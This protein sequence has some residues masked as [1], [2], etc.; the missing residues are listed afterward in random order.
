MTT[1]TRVNWVDGTL[2]GTPLTAARFNTMENGIESVHN[3]ILIALPIG[4]M[5]FYGKN[6]PPAGWLECNGAGLSTTTYAALF[7]AIAYTFGGSG[8]T[9]N[10]PDLRGRFVRAYDNSTGRDMEGNRAIGH[11]QAASNKSHQH[12]FGDHQPNAT[13][14]NGSPATPYCC[15]RNAD[16]TDYTSYV[17]SEFRPKNV[18]LLPIIKY[19]V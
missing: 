16:V 5:A 15:Y 17:G 8:G 14:G 7:A 9:F 4:T 18:A 10:I 3:E 11:V 13:G 2:G 6:T 19:S 1:Y 12:T